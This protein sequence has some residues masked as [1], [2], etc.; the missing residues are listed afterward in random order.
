MPQLFATR[1]NKVVSASDATADVRL[2]PF[3]V[4]Y[5]PRTSVAEVYVF[6]NQYFQQFVPVSW[7]F[8]YI[9]APETGSGVTPVQSGAAATT[10]A[11]VAH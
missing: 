4:V 3:D 8:S 2:A 11:P 9:V 5:V 7:G 6:F 1:Y 10:V